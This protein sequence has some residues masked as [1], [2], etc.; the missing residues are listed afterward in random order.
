MSDLGPA[1]DEANEILMDLLPK[2]IQ[3]TLN[4]LY[5]ESRELEEWKE[6]HKKIIADRGADDEQ[7]CSCCAPLRMELQR[8]QECI[9]NADAITAA[10]CAGAETGDQKRD[11]ESVREALAGT[12][13]YAEPVPVRDACRKRAPLGGADAEALEHA[14]TMTENERDASRFAAKR[15]KDALRKIY[16]ADFSEHGRYAHGIAADAL[17]LDT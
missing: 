12:A 10:L 8:L 3:Q 4:Q 5:N 1:P 6:T 7:H 16:A 13:P 11:L 17:N 9:R 2:K 14:L 15:Y